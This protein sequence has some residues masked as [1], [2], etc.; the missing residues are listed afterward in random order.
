S[1]KKPY[2]VVG[3][4]IDRSASTPTV[5][6]VMYGTEA[7]GPAQ[8]MTL[9]SAVNNGT[10]V[11]AELWGLANPTPGTHQIMVTVTN[12]GGVTM[13]VVA[14]ARSFSNVL[15]TAATGA[16][17]TATGTSLTPAVAVTNGAFDQVVDAVAYNGNVALTPNASQSNS[18]NVTIAAPVFSGAGS[19]RSGANNV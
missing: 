6:G 5:T 1:S 11:R 4:S 18:F 13:S 16:A 17:V 19:T 3:V 2:L 8:A 9:I 14:G 7:G 12:A 10:A 15:Q